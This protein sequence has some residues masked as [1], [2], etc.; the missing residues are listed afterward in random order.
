MKSAV[1]SIALLLTVI[2][3]EASDT[4]TGTSPDKQFAILCTDSADP[5]IHLVSLPS[6]E[7]LIADLF[8]AGREPLSL[9]TRDS[10]RVA[11]YQ[12]QGR[13]SICR[14]FRRR[15]GSFAELE[16]PE[17]TLPF[18]ASIEPRVSKWVGQHDTP[19]R[20]QGSALVITASGTVNLSGDTTID[21]EYDFN[22]AFDEHGK[23]KITGVRKKHYAKSRSID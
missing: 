18:A 22:I 11:C 19:S 13:F 17:L 1:L 7:V 20:W 10:T 3:S 14:A 2:C 15:N 6:R 16:I 23:G 8:D 5:H 4:L 9:W 21:Y 12:S